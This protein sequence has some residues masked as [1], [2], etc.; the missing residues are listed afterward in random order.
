MQNFYNNES[1]LGGQGQPSSTNYGG[2][3]TESNLLYRVGLDVGEKAWRD[4]S[5]FLSKI[6]PIN[7]LKKRF[8]VS[9]TYVGAKLAMLLFPFGKSF[10][11]TSASYD[12]SCEVVADYYPPI[13]DNC[14][15]DL[16]LPSMG[17]FTYVVISAFVIGMQNAAR[18]LDP[19]VLPST[20]SFGCLLILVEAI[21]VLCY[22]YISALAPAASFLDIVALFGYLFV[23]VSFWV[24]LRAFLTML[25]GDDSVLGFLFYLIPLY[26][27]AAY[28]F[29]VFK[30]LSELL[31]S[32]G[33]LPGRALPAVYA[34]AALQLPL[35]YWT[36]KRS[37]G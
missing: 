19:A 18:G 35:L 3:S 2:G 10:Q 20:F 14:A 22:R 28:A 25:L 32:H 7:D 23:P 37:F 6:I 1:Q 27:G 21:L 31:A 29:F 11:R 36:S 26:F 15:P 33:T 24:L 9:H 34:F 17:L 16:Y 12:D 4:S 5:S 13:N 8:Q 30:T